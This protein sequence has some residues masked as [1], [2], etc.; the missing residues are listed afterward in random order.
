M[1]FEAWGSMFKKKEKPNHKNQMLALAELPPLL[2]LCLNIGLTMSVPVA[3][4]DLRLTN[5]S[6]F[7]IHC[8]LTGA[9][10]F[11]KHL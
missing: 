5:C 8:T 2:S 9:T 7:F 10:H 1:Y 6:L 3:P 11:L 4:I